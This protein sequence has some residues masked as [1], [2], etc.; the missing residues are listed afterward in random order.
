MWS[1][2]GRELFYRSHRDGA[3]T[4]VTI[5][6]APTLSIGVPTVLFA[7]EDDLIQNSRAWDVAPDGRFLLLKRDASVEID[8][9]RELVLVQN[10][11]KELQRLVP[12]R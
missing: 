10:W 5:Q 8:T 11:H 1:P 7:H 9:T 2:D 6:T 12:T 4:A 3:M